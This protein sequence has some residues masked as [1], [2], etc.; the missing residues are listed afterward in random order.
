MKRKTNSSPSDSRVW[1]GL[2]HRHVGL[3]LT[4]EGESQSSGAN[5][6]ETSHLTRPLA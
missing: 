2:D 6:S 5:G 3:L 4:K 1:Q